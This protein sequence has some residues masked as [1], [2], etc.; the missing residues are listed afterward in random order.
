MVL[1]AELNELTLSVSETELGCFS[2]TSPV[3]LNILKNHSCCSGLNIPCLLNSLD[4]TIDP[5]GAS[6]SS[7]RQLVA[8][9]FDVV[10]IGSEDQVKNVADGG[11]TRS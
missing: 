10:F 5:V 8:F 7:R 1:E 2:I 4:K 3:P 9:Q 6:L 11:T